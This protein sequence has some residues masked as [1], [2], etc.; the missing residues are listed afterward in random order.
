MYLITR[1]PPD[2]TVFPLVPFSDVFKPEK[3]E[4]KAAGDGAVLKLS[5]KL[6]P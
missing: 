5:C 1:Q 2:K 3:P 4:V 6:I